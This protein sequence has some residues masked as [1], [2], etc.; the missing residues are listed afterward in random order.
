[1]RR[2]IWPVL[3]L[4]LLLLQGTAAVFFTGWLRFDLLL[5]ALY[6]FALFQGE[7]KGAAAGLFV[8]LLQDAVSAACFGFHMLTRMLIGYFTGLTRNKVFQDSYFYHIMIIGAF[9]FFA[10]FAAWFMEL[11]RG[12][13]LESFGNYFAR[14]AGY[15]LGNMLLAVPMVTLCK[16]IAAW[17]KRED[18]SY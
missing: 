5:T 11:V 4:F 8:G 7:R 13:G 17:I 15:C 12:G 6:G 9:S 16:K 1:M 10:E 3:F 18:I 14:A 2:L